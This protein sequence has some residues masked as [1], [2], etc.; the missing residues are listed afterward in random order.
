MIINKSGMDQKTFLKN[1]ENRNHSRTIIDNETIIESGLIKFFK[2]VRPQNSIIVALFKGKKLPKY[3][4]P[5]LRYPRPKIN[6]PLNNNLIRIYLS[7]IKK[8]PSVIDGAILIQV[9]CSVP[10]LRGFSYRIYPPSLDV[11]RSKNNMGSGYNSSFDFSGVKR[12][13]CV[14]FINKNGVIKFINGKGIILC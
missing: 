2:D 4:V 7:T 10:I 9:D 1:K 14:Y 12:I 11:L 5:M 6:I 13:I 8:N 3:C